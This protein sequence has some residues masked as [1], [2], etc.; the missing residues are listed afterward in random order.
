MGVLMLRLGLREFL[1]RPMNH[2]HPMI[3]LSQEV[4]SSDD[5]LDEEDTS[6]HRRNGSDKKEELNLS[7]KGSGKTEVVNT[8]SS[9]SRVSTAEASVST[10][11]PTVSTAGLSTSTVGTSTGILTT[12]PPSQPSDTRDKGKGIMVEPDPP[13]KIKRSD[14]GDLQLQADAE[15]AQLL[16]QEELD[17][18]ERRQRERAAQEAST[19]NM[20]KFNHNQLKGKSYEELQRLYEREQKWI[21]DFVPMDSEKE[22]KKL[23]MPESKGNKEKRIK[24][25]TDSALKHKS[26]KKQKMMQEQESA[27]SDEEATTDYKHEK[28]ELRI[29]LTIVPDEEDIT[30]YKFQQI[31]PPKR[32][33]TSKAS[34]MSQAAIRK[35]VTDSVA[36]ALETQTTTMAEADNSIREIPVAKRGNYKEFTSC[37]PFYFNGTKGVVALIHW[38]KRTESVFSRSNCAEENKVAF[39][40]GTLTNDALS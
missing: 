38:F 29:W 21:H 36:T 8:A 26:S 5:D 6:K 33:S 27:N 18:V 17:E 4:E 1:N 13:V 10:A 9:V 3:N 19:A 32:S 12:P 35:L 7:D 40:T 22:E 31:M 11:R 2:L 16:H 20:G 30:T 15:L 14:Q 23:V 37:Q 28:E 25:V 39:T 34:T 24:R